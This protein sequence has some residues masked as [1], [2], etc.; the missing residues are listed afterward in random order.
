M[1][2][3]Y[4]NDATSIDVSIYLQWITSKLKDKL[5]NNQCNYDI[6]TSNAYLSL[7]THGE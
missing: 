3:S 2:P 7:S 5:L 6:F 1:S 4:E